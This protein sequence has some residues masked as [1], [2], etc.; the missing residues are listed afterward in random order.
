VSDAHDLL[1][2]TRREQ[3]HPPA[4]EDD[5]TCEQLAVLLHPNDND[6]DPKTDVVA[7]TPDPTKTRK[8]SGVGS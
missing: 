4:L 6:A 1:A 5:A 2:R 3:G 8:S 7:T